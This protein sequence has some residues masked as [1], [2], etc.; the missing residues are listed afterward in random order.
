MIH[1]A[2]EKKFASLAQ[3]ALHVRGQ[4]PKIVSVGMFLTVTSAEVVAVSDVKQIAHASAGTFLGED[5]FQV[6]RR[7]AALLPEK[8]IL[9]I[10]LSP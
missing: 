7:S 8:T 10:I 2:A 4:F 9:R 6:L 3:A 5:Y 1:Q